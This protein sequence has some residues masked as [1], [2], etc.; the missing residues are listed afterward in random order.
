MLRE[1][2]H[3]SVDTARRVARLLAM[4]ARLRETK[5]SS[6]WWPSERAASDRCAAAAR[7]VL[8]DEAFASACAEG[9]AMSLDEALDELHRLES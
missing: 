8:G 1:D 6:W 4:T 2:G 5:D 7:A 3:L 9:R